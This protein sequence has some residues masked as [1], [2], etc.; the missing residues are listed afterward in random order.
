MWNQNNVNNVDAGIAA[1][2][3]LIIAI[4]IRKSPVGNVPEKDTSASM[5]KL[6]SICVQD[7]SE[8]QK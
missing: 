1:G 5:Y 2:M 6:K 8:H 4:T 7:G 3:G